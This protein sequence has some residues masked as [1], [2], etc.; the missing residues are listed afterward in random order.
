[1]SAETSFPRA[2]RW[3]GPPAGFGADEPVFATDLVVPEGCTGVRLDL[4]GLGLAVVRVD[5]REPDDRRLAPA[6]S[7]Y[8]RTVWFETY[9]LSGL[10]AGTHRLT[11]T[12]GR[13]FFALP[14]ENVWGWHRA[15]WTGPL[16]LLADLEVSGPDGAV[17]S[18]S[19]TGW[20]VTAGGTTTNCLYAGES[21]D[22][23]KEPGA[24]VPAAPAEPPAGVLRPRD[25][26]PVRP[27]WTGPV[28]WRRIGDSWVGDAGRTVAGWVRLRT[29]QA[30]GA[31]VRIR[32]AEVPEPDGTLRPVNRHVTGDRFQEDRYVGDGTPDQHWEPS[33]TYKGFRWV[34]LDGL[35]HEPGPETVTVVA[36]HSDVRRV[37]VLT[38]AEPLFATY[39]DAMARTIT[40]NLHHLP[41]DTPAYEKNGWTGDAQVGAPTMLY[42]L[43][44]GSLL[45]KW[46]ED[47]VDAMH[48]DG[49]LPVIFPTPGW[50]YHD[51]A[52]SPEWTTVYPF[53][54]RELY[55]HRGEPALLHRHADS[56]RRYLDWELGQLVDGLCVS[57]L[58]DYLAPG[59]DGLGPDDSV[60]TATAFLIRGLG[61]GAEVA[62][63]VGR[64]EDAARW[65]A[66]AA[67]LTSRLHD[68]CFDADAGC[69][70]VG[71]AYSQTAN[72]VM[73]AFGLVPADRVAAVAAGLA[74][75]VRAR[76]GHHHVG[77]LG[78]ATLLTALTRNG[79]PELAL[80]VATT[81]TYPG[82]GFWFAQ[83]A[84]TMWEMWEETTRSRNHYF[85]GTVVQWL[86]EDVVG[87]RR[88][89]HGWAD[90]EVAPATGFPASLD[91]ASFATE[92]VRGRVAVSWR[93][94]D[95]GREVSVE[96]PAGS[97]AR[98]V[99]RDG[100]HDLAEGR[101][102]LTDREPSAGG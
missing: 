22:A 42:L 58:G 90:F 71:P 33:Y 91:H 98:V 66:A 34:Q 89:D 57:A 100:V 86:I 25:F 13:G 11:V 19:D 31:E 70:V 20:T 32:Y 65:R 97:T 49:A 94:V 23:T 9:D 92:T 7:A 93:T 96:V 21:F 82:W 45:A 76:G 41:T 26:P 85:H 40:N 15:P 75:D 29:D 64:P 52:P 5:G 37:G 51:L 102:T 54:L 47:A 28:R 67:A 60:L 10:A 73:L 61:C 95:A 69:Y 8:D 24:P 18:G 56:L 46:L 59:T 27:T 30:R 50:G 87:L 72:A 1:M 14:T 63:L 4:A 80:E 84:D 39:T 101:W 77:C 12:L 78:A 3:I 62:E 79:H 74:A 16:R 48:P 44:A 55:R 38:A 99:L 83:G 17:L 6:F 36:A 53:L 2:G 88:G 68:R 43:D 35:T 81:R